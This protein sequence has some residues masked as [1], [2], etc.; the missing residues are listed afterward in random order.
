[1]GQNMHTPAAERRRIEQENLK[2]ARIQH[3]VECT[4]G[5][6]AEK[7]IESITMNEIASQAEIG[8]ASLYRY[9]T[10]K[11]ELAIDVATYAW[12]TEEEI[13]RKIFTS[14]EYDKMNG[15]NQIKAL[16]EI[17]PEALITQS[18]FFRFIYYFDSFVKKERVTAEK[19]A[20]Y[21]SAISNIKQVVTSAIEKGIEDGSINYKKSG[22]S[23][24]SRAGV[25]E[26]YFTLLHALFSL[27]Q[28][29]SLS[30]EML[31][32]DREV[33]PENQINLL[34]NIML[35]ALK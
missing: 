11:E 3:I 21:E 1:M 2:A 29:L 19:L 18:S 28:K 24:V 25:D 26:V 34:I 14:D 9:F 30:G 8:V 22:N 13:F 4:F 27:A 5:L 12:K 7:G 20:D 35:E 31:Y 32:M 23:I 10:T 6:F 17:F 15:F 33:R 16:L